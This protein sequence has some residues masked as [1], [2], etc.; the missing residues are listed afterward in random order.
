MADLRR[1][2][3]LPVYHDRLL[4]GIKFPQVPPSRN[5]HEVGTQLP[6]N[7][8]PGGY[9]P[10]GQTLSSVRPS[11]GSITRGDTRHRPLLSGSTYLF[12]D[13]Y[14]SPV[15][16]SSILICLAHI[17]CKIVGYPLRSLWYVAEGVAKPSILR[18]AYVH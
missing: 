2:G 14:V 16:A 4:R 3:G 10:E 1:P 9:P 6:R 7:L 15:L 12:V 5:F 18:R 17:Y 11:A 8:T 13:T